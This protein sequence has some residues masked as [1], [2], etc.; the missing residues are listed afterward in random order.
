MPAAVLS[1]PGSHTL[2]EAA[3]GKVTI[4]EFLDYQ[5]PACAG[6]FTNITSKLEKDYAGKV[7][8]VV[9]NFPLG[10][11]PLAVPAARA[12]ESAAEQGKFSEMYHV[13]YEN[14]QQWAVTPDGQSVSE[15]AER[16]N[17]LF[18]GY[19]QRIGLDVAKFTADLTAPAVQ[20]RIDK[21]T[22]DGKTAGV[23]GTPALFVNGQRFE[24]SGQT[25]ADVD[26]QLRELVDR[27]LA[28]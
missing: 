23:T 21:D 9:R 20:A 13:L 26:K 12:A 2:T 27:E 4:T 15:D 6:Y 28:E 22:A 11:H 14:F 7:T 25:F 17:E 8:F 18:R 3:D 10:M 19:A 24:P 16:A 5:C 1:P